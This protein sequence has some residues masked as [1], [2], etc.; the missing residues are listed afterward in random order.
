[1]RHIPA[2]DGDDRAFNE[3]L[4]L[5]VIPKFALAISVLCITACSTEPAVVGVLSGRGFELAHGDAFI[6]AS[7]ER[8]TL[9]QNETHEGELRTV[10]LTLPSDIVVG[11]VLKVGTA[12]GTEAYLHVS[13]GEQVEF[14][15]PDGTTIRTAGEDMRT[16]ASADGTIVV[17]EWSATAKS[18]HFDVELNDG[19][20]IS[21]AFFVR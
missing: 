19:G 20:H 16:A 6:K 1:M 13:A 3:T 8:P 10:S 9:I 7:N 5:M 21:G 2:S 11:E 17:D 12:R 14:Q 15:R 18:G 4:D